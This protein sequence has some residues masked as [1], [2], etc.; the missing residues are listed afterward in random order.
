M[1][2]LYTSF[3][4]FNQLFSHWSDWLS[5]LQIRFLIIRQ[6][7]KISSHSDSF[8]RRQ[9]FLF[10]NVW[11]H[12]DQIIR[13]VR[14]IFDDEFHSNLIWINKLSNL[15]LLDQLLKFFYSQMIILWEQH[16]HE[17]I[18]NLF[19]HYYDV[20]IWFYMKLFSKIFVW[21][22]FNRSTSD[23]RSYS[24]WWIAIWI[25]L[26]KT[27]CDRLSLIYWLMLLLLLLKR[28]FYWLLAN[29]EPSS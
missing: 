8:L 19:V 17:E 25:F 28:K 23:K 3:N 20:T 2:R 21:D 29:D 10:R 11:L 14:I 13:D 12:W 7:S 27:C 18:K 16:D 6:L 5:L 24:S 1:N 4:S 15:V 26:M 9:F 22:L